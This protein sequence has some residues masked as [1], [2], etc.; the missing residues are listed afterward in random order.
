MGDEIIDH[1]TG[2]TVAIPFFSLLSA[3]ENRI[4][5]SIEQVRASLIGLAKVEDVKRVEEHIKSVEDHL[6]RHD[7]EIEQLRADETADA[8]VAAHK[9]R[10][11]TIVGAVVGGVIAA[12]GASASLIYAVSV[13]H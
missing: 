9:R 7:A 3:T 4:Q 1:T 13:L 8:N 6:F 10:T 12:T 2:V 11:W 5:T